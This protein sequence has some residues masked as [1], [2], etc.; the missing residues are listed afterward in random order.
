MTPKRAVK[1]TGAIA[2][3]LALVAWTAPAQ[4]QTTHSHSN[5]NLIHDPKQIPDHMMLREVLRAD[6]PSLG[7]NLRLS[8]ADTE[9]LTSV[10]QQFTREHA[11]MDGSNAGDESSPYE[12]L[13]DDLSRRMLLRLQVEMSP[14]GQAALDRY[15]QAEKSGFWFSD[16]DYGLGAVAQLRRK[17]RTIEALMVASGRPMVPGGPMI[18][19]YSG[20]LDVSYIGL[21][22]KSDEFSNASNWEVYGGTWSFTKGN[23]H[24]TGNG[25]AGDAVAYYNYSPRLQ[26]ANSCQS[27]T[28]GSVGTAGDYAGVIFRGTETSETFYGLVVDTTSSPAIIQ[29]YYKINGTYN[30]LTSANY[31]PHAGDRIEGCL[32]GNQLRATLNS[33]LLFNFTDSHITAGGYNGMVNYATTNGLT[34]G[35]FTTS[36]PGGAL[37]TAVISGNTQCPLGCPAGATHQP[38]NIINGVRDVGGAVYPTSQINYQNQVQYLVD[39]QDG[40]TPI[41]TNS[42][43]QVYCTG[44]GGAIW[45][46]PDVPVELEEAK[47]IMLDTGASTRFVGGR[48]V[49]PMCATAT[50]TIDG[51]FYTEGPDWSPTDVWYDDGDPVIPAPYYRAQTTCVRIGIGLNTSGNLEPNNGWGCLVAS[52][53]QNF[54]ELNESLKNYYITSPLGDGV[55][56]YC[57]IWDADWDGGP[58]LP[59]T[60]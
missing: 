53:P 42:Q 45:E 30:Y 20:G 54:Y 38:Q 34:I 13:V 60:M 1:L 36:T 49:S 3:L 16:I 18:V 39:G 17:Q 55:V 57:T 24:A 26:Q 35:Q 5:L 7:T 41:A 8:R 43:E 50:V 2:L 27:F 25:S 14:R 56:S 19:N 32:Q 47:V 11:T 15:L 48:A 28:I 10:R 51:G 58:F 23:A 46:I 37:V 59:S 44:I 52:G 29:A 22:T 6:L 40:G 21:G 31:T 4:G 12:H 33:N 9:I